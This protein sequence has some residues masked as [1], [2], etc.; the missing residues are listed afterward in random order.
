MVTLPIYD[1]HNIIR[2]FFETGQPIP[3]LIPQTTEPPRFW[4]FDGANSREYRTAIFPGYKS[5]KD[6]ETPKS[7]GSY[8]MIDTIRRELLPHCNNT[9]ILQ[10]P[11]YEADDVIAFLVEMLL[12]QVPNGTHYKIMSN[13]GDLHALTEDRVSLEVA[14]ALTKKVAPKDVRIFKTL[15]G[16]SSDCIPG[17]P[18]FGEGAFFKESDDIRRQWETWCETGDA[19]A[20]FPVEGSQLRPGVRERLLEIETRRNLLMY[21]KVIQPRP[22]DPETFNKHLTISRDNPE[23]YKATL[24]KYY[25]DKHPTSPRS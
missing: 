15:V 20:P 11:G 7:D 22:L 9:F 17:L 3:S 25:W 13:D 19:F 8:A 4:V 2:R 16:D 18:G 10:I 14:T 21:W 6:T 5:R 23:A 12:T 24:A 1:G